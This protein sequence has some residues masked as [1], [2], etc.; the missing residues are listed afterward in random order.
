VTGSRDPR[1]GAPIGSAGWDMSAEYL[2]ALEL[3]L[4]DRGMKCDLDTHAIWPRLRVHSP[5]EASP[6]SVADFENSIVAA[7]FD[8]GWWFAWLWAEKITEVTGIEAAADRIAVELGAVSEAPVTA[9][10]VSLV[11]P[12]TT[13]SKGERDD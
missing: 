5:Y 11:P 1:R 13:R 10:R 7:P 8:D 6:P 12:L 2:R 3:A 9:N 4:H